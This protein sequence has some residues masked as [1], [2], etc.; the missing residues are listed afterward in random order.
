MILHVV[1]YQPKASTTAEELAEFVEAIERASREIPSIQQ[2]RIG[3]TTDIGFS[4]SGRSLSQEMSYM[5]LFEFNDVNGLRD[6]LVHPQHVELS[7]LFWMVCK[8]T[9]IVDVEAVDPRVT[10]LDKLLVK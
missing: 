1:F 7:Q 8:E 10:G 4:Y 3:K 9:M 6:Y 2:V 5:A